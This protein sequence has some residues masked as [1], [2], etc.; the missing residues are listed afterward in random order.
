M[1]NNNNYLCSYIYSVSVF[2]NFDITFAKK[3]SYIL[4]LTRV[5]PQEI[6]NFLWVFPWVTTNKKNCKVWE[7]GKVV[8]IHP[9]HSSPSLYFAQY[10]SWKSKYSII[11]ILASRQRTQLMMQ[12][13]WKWQL[14]IVIILKACLCLHADW[15]ICDTPPTHPQSFHPIPARKSREIQYI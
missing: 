6:C 15:P 14:C 8:L 4:F 10:F 3:K 11:W 5:L 13:V 7:K 12:D 1:H 9:L 2:L